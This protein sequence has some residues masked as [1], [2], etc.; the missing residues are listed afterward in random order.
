MDY[1][2]FIILLEFAVT[3]AIVA[4]MIRHYNHKDIA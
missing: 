1:S 4:G 3:M 2:I